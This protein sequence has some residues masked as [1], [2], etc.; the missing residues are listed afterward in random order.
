LPAKFPCRFITWEEV[1]EMS[2]NLAEKIRVSNFRPDVIVAVAR[3]GVVGA[4]L[5]SDIL[6]IPDFTCLRIAHWGETAVRGKDAR[7]ERGIG[8]TVSGKKILLIDDVTD[9]GKSLSVAK[10]YLQSLTPAEIKTAALQYI[11]GSSFIPDFYGKEE[12]EWAW[13]AYPWN[14][15]E[16]LRSLTLRIL[17]EEHR[18]RA[19]K[20]VSEKFLEYYGV[21]VKPEL[22]ER[23]FKDLENKGYGKKVQDSFIMKQ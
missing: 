14:R 16:D 6:G 8:G 23:T 15:W 7:L 21:N 3:G 1:E 20:E 11:K 2:Y 4:R 12:T 19:A 9:T 18:P 13:F 10:A 5:V 22:I 17:E